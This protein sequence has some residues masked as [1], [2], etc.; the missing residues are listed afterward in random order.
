MYGI[1]YDDGDIDLY[2]DLRELRD[3]LIWSR[4]QAETNPRLFG[5]AEPVVQVGTNPDDLQWETFEDAR[6]E[7]PAVW[8]EWFPDE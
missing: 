6:V 4:E 3:D 8:W 5:G 7:I 2:S 1:R